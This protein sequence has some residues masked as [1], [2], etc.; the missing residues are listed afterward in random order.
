MIYDSDSTHILRRSNWCTT[1]NNSVEYQYFAGVE[2]NNPSGS[3]DNLKRE[4]YKDGFG[5]TVFIINY[6]YDITNRFIGEYSTLI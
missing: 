2:D 6:I 4:I 5:D 1:L 3:T